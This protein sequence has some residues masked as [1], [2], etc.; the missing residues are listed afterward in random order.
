MFKFRYYTID[1]NIHLDNL[2]WKHIFS[3]I[4]QLATYILCVKHAS[5]SLHQVYRGHLLMSDIFSEYA[6]SDFERNISL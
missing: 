4:F 3:C 2:Y 1:T 6:V 5:Y